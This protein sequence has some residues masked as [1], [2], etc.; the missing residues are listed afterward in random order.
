[1]SLNSNTH[2]KQDYVL[3]DEN[4]TRGLQEP[5]LVFLLEAV[6]HWSLIKYLQQLYRI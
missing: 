6:I 2:E 5:K 3:I 1:M 4:V